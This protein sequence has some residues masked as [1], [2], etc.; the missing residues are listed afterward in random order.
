MRRFTLFAAPAAVLLLW[1]VISKSGTVDRIFLSDPWSVLVALVDGLRDGVLIG[2]LFA[3]VLRSLAG[4]LLATV[5]GVPLGL[6]IGRR[7]S[8]AQALQPT[9]DFFRSV[10]A[11]A[12]FPMFLFVFGIG[13]VAKVA[14]A[15]Y[16]CALI[17]LVN[18]SYGAIQVRETRVRAARIMGANDQSIFW[19]IVVPEAL[20]SI[21][22]GLRIALSLAFVLV[23]VTEMFIGTTVG[24]GYEIINSQQLYR[25]PEMYAAIVLAGVVGYLGNRALIAIERRLLHWVGR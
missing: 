15:V 3:T 21:F 23:V 22:A 10:P 7:P 19:K 24:L 13:D 1:L 20:P 8:V 18:A 25:I 2:D 16:G 9:I 12:L 4:F 6:L 5:V 11:T 17:V 14:V